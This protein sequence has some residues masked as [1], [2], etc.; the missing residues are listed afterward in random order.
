MRDT[1]SMLLFLGIVLAITGLIHT[2]LYRGLVRGLGITAPAALWTLRGLAVLLAVSYILTRMIDGVAPEWLVHSA[3]WASSVWMGLMFYLLSIGLLVWLAKLVLRIVGV[4][5]RLEPQHALLGRVGV[6]GVSAAALA[7]V[8]V[9]MIT[10]QRPARVRAVKV[11]V[12][13]ITPEL[14][15]L[16]IAMVADFHAGVLAG[17]RQ[18]T[19]WV[20]EINALEPD[21]VLV[22]G[23][24]VDHPLGVFATTGNHEYYVGLERARAFLEESGMR[25]LLNERVEVPGGLIVAGIEDRTARSMG[26]ELPSAAEILGPDAKDRPAVFLNH[27]PARG[28]VR[29]AIAAGADLVVSGHTH[30][31]Q[32]WPFG[33]VTRLAFPLHHGLYEVDGGHQLTT[34]GIGYWGPP[35]RL[36]TAPEIFLIELVGEDEAASVEP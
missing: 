6:I 5:S 18:V 14:A 36:G 28:S 26:R 9:A 3:H 21:L 33:I 35:M 8:L 34:C 27:T 25:L 10:A 16:R 31:G 11:P 1:W 30:G 12:K 22:P 19:R 15:K 17:E 20:G 29:E 4:W 13:A 23:D 24:I 32:I 2:F 7:L